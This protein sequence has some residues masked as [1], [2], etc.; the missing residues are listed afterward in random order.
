VSAA[1]LALENKNQPN[2]TPVAGPFMLTPPIDED[3]WTYRVRLSDTQAIV[4]FPKFLTVGVGFAVEGDDWNCNLPYTCDAR[5]IYEHIEHNK[6]D[7]AISREDCIAAIEMIQAAAK[8][9]RAACG[10]GADERCEDCGRCHACPGARCVP[11]SICR[12][13]C[14]CAEQETK[15]ALAQCPVCHMHTNTGDH[16]HP[17]AE[18]ARRLIALDDVTAVETIDDTTV[19]VTVQPHD[20]DTW[21]WWLHRFQVPVHAVTHR[22]N[23]TATAKGTAPGGVQVLIVAHGVNALQPPAAAYI[24]QRAT[25]SGG[26]RG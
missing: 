18:V 12:C 11:C 6:G 2:K 25:E 10:H 1:N 16:T 13:S 17:A 21:R 8:T 9:D 26:D 4:G 24:T 7:D 23:D 5:Q 15:P 22:G 19:A 14:E 3:Y 20:L